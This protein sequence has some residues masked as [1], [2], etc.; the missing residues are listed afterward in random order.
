MHG[1]VRRNFQIALGKNADFTSSAMELPGN[2][3]APQ[4]YYL[5]VFFRK[6]KNRNFEGKYSLSEVST[7][8]DVACLRR[9][10]LTLP[11]QQSARPYLAPA[12]RPDPCCSS[13]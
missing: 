3:N 9:S 5:S 7:A 2:S 4:V 11:L 12:Q 8:S 10:L 13:D 1:P 6:E